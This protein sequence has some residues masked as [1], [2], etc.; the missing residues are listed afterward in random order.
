MRR[1]TGCVACLL[2]VLATASCTSSDGLM[3]PAE[4]GT[5]GPAMQ[6]TAGLAPAPSTTLAVA[7]SASGSTASPTVAGGT[8]LGSESTPAFAGTEPSNPASAAA[9]PQGDGGPMA[10]IATQS[11]L[12]F[13][14]ITGA[15]S[16]VA[17]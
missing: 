12:E 11:R 13:A 1:S 2:A 9:V 7:P 6:A 16:Q 10:A 4:V 17:T 14:P 15:T 8:T 5:S 3:P